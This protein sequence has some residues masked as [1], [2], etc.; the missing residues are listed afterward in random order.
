[1][2]IMVLSDSHGRPSLIEKAISSQPQ[3]EHI[4][5]LGDCTRDIDTVAPFFS[6]RKF[7]IVKGNCDFGSDYPEYDFITLENCGIF[8][9]HGH[10]FGVKGS[11]E[12][13]SAFAGNMGASI[14]LFGHTHCSYTSYEDGLHIVNPGS[15]SLPRN[16]RASYAVIDICQ[17][18]IMPI[19]INI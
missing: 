4:F 17:N 6:D 11:T 5:F 18:G 16:S 14:A 10:N 3:A 9:C 13:L 12:R 7:H 19:I 2:R 8:Y 15:L 1:M